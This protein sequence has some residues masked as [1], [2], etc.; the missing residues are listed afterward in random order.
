VAKSQESLQP[1]SS[2]DTWVHWVSQVVQEDES[3]LARL[4]DTTCR[5][6]KPSKRANCIVSTG[7][8]SWLVLSHDDR[9]RW[10]NAALKFDSKPRLSTRRASSQIQASSMSLNQRSGDPHRI[11]L[12][13][14][15]RRQTE[16]NWFFLWEVRQTG[17]LDLA[18]VYIVDHPV[19][20]LCSD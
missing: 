8:R 18:L 13:S 2:N 20:N 19:W 9:N 16:K 14:A 6:S 3:A 11:G 15:D 4:Y 5:R 10:R 17:S 12:L 1:R 7:V